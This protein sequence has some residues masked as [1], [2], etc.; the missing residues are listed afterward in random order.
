VSYFIG[1]FK[2]EAAAF[3]GLEDAFADAVPC[4][5]RNDRLRLGDRS[6]Y[7][8]SYGNTKVIRNLMLCDE[9]QR[10]WLAVLGTPLVH[11][12]STQHEQAFLADFLADPAASML[13]KVDGNFAVIAY[14][15]TRDRLIAATDL[16]N[17]TPIFYCR[18][19]QGL[20]F[21]S[22]EL[23]LARL[24]SADID[25]FGFSQSIQLGV[26]WGA[27]TRFAGIHKML[28]CHVSVVSPN[29]GLLA[30][31]YWR[32]RDERPWPG[33]L[34]ESLDRWMALLRDAVWKFYDCAGRTP[35]LTDF[36]AG[37]DA[38]LIVAQCQALGIPFNAQVEGGES[39]A[40][41]IVAKHA[42]TRAGFAL[43]EKRKH[44][45]TNEQLVAAACRISV[46]SD[47]Y[48]SFFK[49]CA[50]FATDAAASPLTDYTAV[51]YCGV[52]GGEAFRGSYY[53]RGK[54]FLPS[55]RSRLDHKFF[56]RMKYLLD[57]HPDLL[58]YPDDECLQRIYGMAEHTLEDVEDSPLGTQIDH[59][60]RVF[61]TCC[62]GLKYKNPLYLPLATNPL[63]RSIY[64]LPPHHKRGGRLTKACTERLFPELAFAKTQNGVPTIRKTLLR[65]HLFLPEYMALL[66]KVSSGAVSRLFKWT[67]ANKWYYS[68]EQNSYIFTALL[69]TPPYGLW[70]SSQATM[71]TGHLYNAR[72]LNSLLDQAKTG[73]CSYVPVLGNVINQELALRWVHGQHLS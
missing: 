19:P 30:E 49:S 52:P 72:T 9:E 44:W 2:I 55:S 32:P 70:F 14:D 1:G 65:T 18:T 66:K 39:D 59:M 51:K 38:R 7:V 17:T 15:A 56:T 29:G 37:E 54:A 5:I 3:R 68:L 12:Q 13:H 26:T 46:L 62:L 8:V 73:S 40:E 67:Q 34:D 31:P 45:P 57:Y 24:L 36:T 69:N 11:F 42:A 33:N 41:V 22:H 16:N 28:P 61:Q 71:I 25:P 58:R 10:S 4:H 27:H 6:T 64:S 48:Q 53:L 23:P 35:A 47:A 63:T 43:T 21:C 20:V 60:L 50:E